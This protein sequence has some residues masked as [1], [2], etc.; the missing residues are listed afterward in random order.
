MA[1]EALRPYAIGDAL[2]PGLAAA[3]AG[4]LGAAAEGAPR[5]LF[6]RA[7]RVERVRR[8]AGEGGLLWVT[9]GPLSEAAAREAVAL[10]AYD[11]LSL[12]DGEALIAARLDELCASTLAVPPTPGLVA[13][14][15]ASRRMLAEVAQ[16]ART[17][18][19]VLITGETG[20][21]KEE[22]ARL[23]HHWSKRRGPW[24]PINCAAIPNELM[25]SELFGHARGAFSGAV[26]SV[27]G[28]LLAAQGGT[29]FLDEID[30]TPMSTQAK[31][32]RVLEDGEVVRLGETEP[33][34]VDFRIVAA[35][36]EDLRRLIAEKRF[37]QDLFERLAIVR[38]ELPPLRQRRE[39]I[40][41]LARHFIDR[42]DVLQGRAPRGIGLSPRVE[43][44][45]VEYDWPGNVR[46]LRNV[47]YQALVGKRAGG[48]LLLSDLRRLLAPGAGASS[49]PSSSPSP[50]RGPL[51]DEQQIAARLDDGSFNLRRAVEE[52]ERAALRLA[53]ARAGGNAAHAARLLGEV[54]RGRARDPGA[55]VRAMLRRL[56][57][58]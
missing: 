38:I 3:L 17:S 35:T 56:G 51:V 49:S 43:A 6:T 47:I 45:L 27:D 24:V 34:K 15:A 12:A 33:R 5:L 52:L 44:L 46:E 8:A 18:M 19:P 4:R 26:A 14:S 22:T 16:A 55:T 29:V 41:H 57:A 32:L 54:G 53:L 42:F 58:P 21:G 37:G 10:G 9:A 13:E 40:P 31:L 39:D 23:I 20:T 28:K 11:A 48:E 25:E 30:D 1:M 7:A 36:N 50:S 2:P